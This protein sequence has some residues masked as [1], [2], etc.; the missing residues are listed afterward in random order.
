[1]LAVAWRV[2]D[3]RLKDQQPSKQ[4]MSALPSTSTDSKSKEAQP[5]S[6]GTESQ[7]EDIAVVPDYKQ[8]KKAPARV[9]IVLDRNTA[10]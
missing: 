1:M 8:Y 4:T 3:K 6:S 5:T 10:D 7:A 9:N 2:V